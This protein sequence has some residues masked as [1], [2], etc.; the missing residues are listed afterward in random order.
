MQDP[1]GGGRTETQT[2]RADD[3]GVTRFAAS[4]EDLG[5]MRTLPALPAG[6]TPRRLLDPS[7]NTSEDPEAAATAQARRDGYVYTLSSQ[8]IPERY[9]GIL[10]PHQTVR[11]DAGATPH[12]G[13]YLITRVVHRITP[14]LY[15]Q[16]LEAKANST[17]EISGAGVA[18]T[19]GGGLF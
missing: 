5:L 16:Q 4:A 1:S 13:D 10:T 8:E 7:D 19:P 2:M 15:S 11:L 17:T 3:R 12:S 9:A 6:L 14:S 18:E